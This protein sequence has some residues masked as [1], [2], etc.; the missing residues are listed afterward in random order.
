[1]NDI[2]T[3]NV[4]L[5][6]NDN[7]ST[8]H[9]TATSDHDNVTGIELDNIDDFVLLKV[10]LDGVVNLDQGVGVTNGSAIVGDDVRDTLG[11][12]SHLLDL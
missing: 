6:V 2:E 11:A 9:V 8:A 10:E 4:L 7:T 3:T 12:D 1:M 5:T